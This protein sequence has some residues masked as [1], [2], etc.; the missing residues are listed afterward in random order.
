MG[1]IL[2][3]YTSKIDFDGIPDLVNFVYIR[4]S[5]DVENFFISIDYID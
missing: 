3:N 5:S 2:A 1:T 4:Y